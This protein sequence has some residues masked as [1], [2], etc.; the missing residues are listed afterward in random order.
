MEQ[1][2]PRIYTKKS[3]TPTTFEQYHSVYETLNCAGCPLRTQ[4][5][6][7]QGNRRIKTNHNFK[8]QKFKTI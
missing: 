3:K 6:K 5:F 7:A 1:Q 2:M 8:R 4:C